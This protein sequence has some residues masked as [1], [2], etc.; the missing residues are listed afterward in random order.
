VGSENY[1][2][3]EFC[4]DKRLSNGFSYQIAYTWSK[5]ID[6]GDDDWLAGLNCQ[7][8][9]DLNAYGCRGVAGIDQ[10][11]F[12]SANFIYEV[13]V[14]RG[15]ALSTGNRVF[16]YLLGNWQ[17]NGIFVAHSGMPFYPY[18]SSDIANTGSV[19]YES[20][21]LIG[22]PNDVQRNPAHWF[23]TAAYT[24]PPLYTFGTTPRNSL[25]A[26]GYWNLDGSLFRLF[27]VGESRRF[28]FRAE[29]FNFLNHADLGQPV[30]DLNAGAAFG[31]IDT[32]ANKARQIQLSAKFIF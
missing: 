3:L 24:V 21:D 17:A 20:A 8:P 16:D 29:A 28:E 18:I 22:N 13:P 26:P 15:K 10:T 23:N 30:A 2:A 14:G 27:P 31:T 11:H 4:L 9:Y 1:N 32:T 12:L 5:N 7:S 19:D 6:N 25:R